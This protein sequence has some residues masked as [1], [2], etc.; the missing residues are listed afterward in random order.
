MKRSKFFVTLI[1][2]L[3]LA[4]FLIPAMSACIAGDPENDN[5][6]NTQTP[7]GG[8]ETPDGGDE[9]PDGG[10]ENPDGG[11][12][13]PDGG[14]HVHVFGEWH[15]VTPP[16]CTE[17]GV[18]GRDCDCGVSDTTP[19]SPKGHSYGEW[20]E[21]SEATCT[22]DGTKVRYC[23]TCGDE[24][25][26]PI[27]K[28]G[29]S[30]GTQYSYDGETHYHEC[31]HCGEKQDI[32]RHVFGSGDECTVCGCMKN[33]EDL[34]TFGINTDGQSYSVTSLKDRSVE[35]ITIPDEYDNLPVT[36]IGNMAFCASSVQDPMP[37]KEIKFGKNI[38]RIEENAFWNCANL[39]S[40]QLP[41]NLEYIGYYAFERCSG[42]TEVTF[43]SKLKTIDYEGFW[44]CTSLTDLDI[45]AS[46]EY[47]GTYAFSW[48]TGLKSI[49]FGNLK[50]LGVQAFYNCNQLKSIDLGYG[51]LV[52]SDYAFCFCT[53]LTDF[54]IGDNT[55]SIGY[56][57]FYESGFDN[58]HTENGVKYLGNAKNK[59]AVA[60][61]AENTEIKELNLGDG[62]RVISNS[63]F[64][65]CTSLTK[66]NTGNVHSIC[67]AAFAGC[68]ALEEV[69][70]GANLKRVE[71]NAFNG[72]KSSKILNLESVDS[73]LSVQ[74]AVSEDG[75]DFLNDSSSPIY[76]GGKVYCGGTEV[77]FVT[78][79]N[80]ITKLSPYAF[81]GWSGLTSVHIGKDVSSIGE[82]AF[83]NCPALK[84]VTVSSQNDS[85][86]GVNNCVV[87]KE[88]LTVIAG[89]T[90]STI[91]SDIKAIAPYAFYQVDFT[92]GVSAGKLTL[93]DSLKTIG[94]YS[95]YDAKINEITIGRG[96][97]SSGEWAFAVTGQIQTVN[98][99]DVVSWCGVDFTDVYSLPFRWGTQ[100]YVGGVCI[101]DYQHGGLKI[102]STVTEIKPYAFYYLTINELSIPKE[103]VKIDATSF[104]NN[105]NLME[106]TLDS[107][108]PAYEM[109]KNGVGV[110][111]KST[112]TLLMG[113]NSTNADFSQDD[114]KT[115][116]EYA[117]SGRPMRKVILPS[118]VT[119]IAAHA[120]SDSGIEQITLP[121]S[122]QSIGDYAFDSCHYLQS[123]TIPAN[124]KSIGEHAFA[125]CDMLSTVDLGNVQR[126]GSLAFFACDQLV[127]V[128]IPES[129]TFIGAGM[130]FG[131]SLFT[132][133]TFA[134]KEG[135]VKKYTFDGTTSAPDLSST[136]AA[137]REL[138]EASYELS[139]EG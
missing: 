17:P 116:G 81:A 74:F 5:Q 76:N 101:T 105:C 36:A 110:I 96:L 15:V 45:P 32:D 47:V 31:E 120:F 65:Y 137:A 131:C 85:F 77:T 37:L 51:E 125:D 99:T 67:N 18:M 57:I 54:S 23:E 83:A 58:F 86:K 119:V 108:N 22:T 56:D 113:E 94:E 12:E 61:A 42:L 33:I 19:I 11:D 73:Y 62:V 104:A 1:M 134:V 39:T 122:L 133:A 10:D 64:S 46:V 59:Y 114:I 43:G 130:F 138:K 38:T 111:E 25:T 63:A 26:E 132:S 82:Y 24:Q 30:F 128:Y 48:C 20:Q 78:I 95:F 121:A 52:I 34:L 135:W 100:V 72:T 103:T 115:V 50:F 2:F 29:H 109:S 4:L 127:S 35:K 124:T 106:I 80:G 41:E 60:F 28:T 126:I 118:S 123:L 8:D 69:T 98:I 84:T 7:D 87:Q 9:N 92:A 75:G 136:S 49:A 55:V 112:R 93:P 13:N 139:R 90:G 91:P 117:F 129:V 70:F 107:A 102:P 3:A 21:V 27:T 97:E 44:G 89:C 6:T 88:S 68:S 79:P 66:V 16:S 40:L 14:E 71:R 53:S